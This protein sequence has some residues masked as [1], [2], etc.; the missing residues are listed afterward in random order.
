MAVWPTIT[1]GVTLLSKALFDSIQTYIDGLSTL[2]FSNTGL[3][4]ED[5][6]AS[7]TLTLAPGSNLTANRTLTLTTGDAA[8]TL[9]LSGNA[10]L[11]QDVSTTGTPQFA[12]ATTTGN[13]TLASGSATAVTIGGGA[14]ASTLRLLE[15]SGSGTNYTAFQ[16]QAQSADVT[17][18]LPAAD[19]TSGQL[20]STNGSG[21]LS[22][23]TPA[24][25][26]PTVLSKSAN[27]TV[28][29]SDGSNVAVLCTNTITITLYA[30]SGNSG[31]VVTVKNN[32]TG[33]VTIDGN[34]SETI[35][36]ALTKIISTPYEALTLVCDGTNWA[37]I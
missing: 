27:Y 26:T 1:N 31:K 16:A 5:T 33:L 34:A 36:G 23:A 17:Y 22:W 30:A 24:S 10:T 29:T 13:T 32:G 28:Q 21:T 9:T 14:T 37:I 8:R 12:G 6:D 4:I 2:T 18:T 35:D 7:H 15:P 11:D 20:L 19:G 3:K 25:G